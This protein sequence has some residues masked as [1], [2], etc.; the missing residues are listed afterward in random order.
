MSQEDKKAL[1]MPLTSR[2]LSAS[3]TVILQPLSFTGLWHS[4]LKVLVDKGVPMWLALRLLGPLGPQERQSTV[5]RSN[6][7]VPGRAT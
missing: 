2:R 7:G 6:S 4:M 5:L 3:R 1:L